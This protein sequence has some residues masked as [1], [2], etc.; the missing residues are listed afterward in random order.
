[1]RDINRLDSLYETIKMIH[2]YYV[3]D[4]RFGQFM[5]NFMNWYHEKY[6]QDCFYVEDDKI[7]KIFRDFINDMGIKYV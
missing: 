4:W 1:M 7:K 5:M 6:K 2:K 3:P